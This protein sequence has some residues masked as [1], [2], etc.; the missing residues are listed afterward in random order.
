MRECWNRCKLKKWKRI[1]IFL[2]DH[3]ADVN[4]R[5]GKCNGGTIL[6]R[7]M[8][9]LLV[10][11]GR[12]DL[13]RYFI[14]RGAD[15]FT[16]HSNRPRN[17]EQTL[18][19]MIADNS[20]KPPMKLVR[21]LHENGVDISQP[22]NRGKTALHMA[23][24]RGYFELVQYLILKGASVNV[25]DGRGNRPL[26]LA[27]KKKDNFD[28]VKFLLSKGAEQ[29]ENKSGKTPAFFIC[30]DHDYSYANLLI[31]RGQTN[32]GIIRDDNRPLS[33]SGLY[34]AARNGLAEI[35]QYDQISLKEK[36]ELFKVGK[37]MYSYN[38]CKTPFLNYLRIICFI[39]FLHFFLTSR[40]EN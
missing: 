13:A 27:V 40:H 26:H 15:I 28:M 12:Y 39:Y 29:V 21:Y 14:S 22:N 38:F 30:R 2:L 37:T 35:E 17:S 20:L 6:G 32:Y 24:K 25:E 8:L 33:Y 18:I 3:G 23:A 4:H 31:K 11:K 1:S 9:E 7:T 10:E 5:A 36:Q 16:L 34:F 19:H